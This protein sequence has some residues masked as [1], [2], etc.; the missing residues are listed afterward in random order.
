[1]THPV[2]LLEQGCW[3]ESLLARADVLAAKP[4]AVP[5]EDAAAFPVPALTA[6]QA[7]GAV[8]GTSGARRL[9]VHGA[10]GM[11]GQLIAALGVVVGA[12]VAVTAGPR[13]AERLRQLGV[14]AVF[15]YH[16]GGWP[17]GVR[18]WAGGDGVAAAI[19]AAPGGEA[20]ALST[21]ADGGRLATITGA[22]PTAARG[23][24]IIDVYV[25]ADGGRLASMAA[26]LGHGEIGI[27]VGAVYGLAA[28]ADALES[29]RP[30]GRRWCGRTARVSPI[31]TGNGRAGRNAAVPP[32]EQSAAWTMTGSQGL[33]SGAP[34]L[35]AR[36]RSDCNRGPLRTLSASQCPN[37]ATSAHIHEHLVVV[38]CR[39]MAGNIALS[40]SKP[41]GGQDPCSRIAPRRS[42]VRVP[43][44]PSQ[45]A[46]HSC[47]FVSSSTAKSRNAPWAF[48]PNELL[49]SRE[50]RSLELAV[51]THGNR[52]RQ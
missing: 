16:D 4:S 3:S 20:A 1:M 2:P 38:P 22:P 44:A 46:L 15:D 33:R 47:G 5:W 17:A 7:V 8:L 35:R 52:R 51:S 32:A 45:E 18:D 49:L 14:A 34:P 43:L 23:V 25:Q 26:R 28:A 37:P 29:G 42:G 12:E 9:L 13:S 36:S 24:T 40:S 50:S 41:A 21:V 30:R 39:A 31:A 10:G 48:V 6:D 27:A 19:N 11:T